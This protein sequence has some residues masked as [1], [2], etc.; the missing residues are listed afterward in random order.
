MKLVTV[1]YEIVDEAEWWQ[2]GPIEAQYAVAGLKT[3]RVGSGDAIESKTALTDLMPFVLDDYNVLG[4]TF[5][6]QEYTDAVERA[7]KA[8]AQ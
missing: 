2:R 7:K 8:V 1:V 3:V 5:A 6:T 4:P